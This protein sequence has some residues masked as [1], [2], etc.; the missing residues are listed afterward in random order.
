MCLACKLSYSP[1]LLHEQSLNH[2]SMK[3][4]RPRCYAKSPAACTICV[5]RSKMPWPGPGVW[6][7]ICKNIQKILIFIKHH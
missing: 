3:I 4:G 7:A 6:G 1:V 2:I 5:E